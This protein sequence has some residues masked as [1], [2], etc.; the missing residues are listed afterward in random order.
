MKWEHRCWHLRTPPLS[1]LPLLG[2]PLS[3]GLANVLKG[4]EAGPQREIYRKSLST[5][6][7]STIDL[8]SQ[9]L[10]QVL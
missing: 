9:V 10:K 7:N 3:K 1:P 2:Y 4:I 5:P 6:F 8:L